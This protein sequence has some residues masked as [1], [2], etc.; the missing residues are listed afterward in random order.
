LSREA[1]TG[2]NRDFASLLDDLFVAAETPA[3]PLSRPT[4]P[5]DYLSVADELH[6]GRIRVSGEAAASEYRQAGEAIEAEL[7]ALLGEVGVEEPAPVAEPV[8][9]L[10]IDPPSIEP[11]AIALELGLADAAPADLGKLR[12]TFAL[13]NHPDRVAPHLRQ[14]ALTRMQVANG[15]IDEAKRRALARTKR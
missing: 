12:R 8:E 10:S 13:K 7:E 11:D 5:F 14:L 15:L 6:S 1:A 4:I 3:E 9:V 2:T